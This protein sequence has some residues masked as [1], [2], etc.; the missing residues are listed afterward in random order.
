MKRGYLTLAVV[1]IAAAVAVFGFSKLETE[2][3]GLNLNSVD[4]AFSQYM[5]KNGKSYATKEE[6]NFRKNLFELNM[7][8]IAEHNSRNDVSWT[9]KPNKF[10]DMTPEEIKSMFKGLIHE[11]VNQADGVKHLN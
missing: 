4:Q 1:G 6:Y 2:A 8:M 5:A 7:A 3:F 10:S 9:L 11:D